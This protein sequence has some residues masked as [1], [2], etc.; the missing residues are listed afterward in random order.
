MYN[1]ELLCFVNKILIVM[2]L[3]FDVRLN[4]KIVLRL[5]IYLIDA[6]FVLNYII[7]VIF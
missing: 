7:A 3:S 6:A 5:C 1:Y 4:I 2:Y